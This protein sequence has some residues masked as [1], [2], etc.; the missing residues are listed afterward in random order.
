MISNELRRRNLEVGLPKAA[1]ILIGGG[2]HHPGVAVTAGAA[3]KSMIADAECLA[4]LLKLVDPPAAELVG[5]VGRDA[6]E[7]RY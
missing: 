5:L 7:L 2:V 6:R 4:R 1:R 3:K